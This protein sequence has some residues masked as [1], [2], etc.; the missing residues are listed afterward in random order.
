MKLFKCYI[1]DLNV[2]CGRPP[3]LVTKIKVTEEFA[4]V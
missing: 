2:K 4:D 3:N 1:V